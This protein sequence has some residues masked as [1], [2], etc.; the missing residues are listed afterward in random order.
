MGPA[1]PY[2][3]AALS[4]EQVELLRLRLLDAADRMSRD[5]LLAIADTLQDAI[6]RKQHPSWHRHDTRV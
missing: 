6:R 3:Q 4:D 1:A 5:Q 2:V